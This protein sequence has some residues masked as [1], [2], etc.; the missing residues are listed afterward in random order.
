ML[1]DNLKQRSA[2]MKSVL[3]RLVIGALVIGVLAPIQ[4]ANAAQITNR[5]LT[6]GT[7]QASVSTTHNYTFTAPTGTTIL[8]ID[9]TYCTT[10]SG[11]CT[12]PSGLTT[13]TAT[14]GSTSNLGSGGAWTIGGTPTNGRIQISN[15]SNTGS[16]SAAATV[17]FNAVT[18]P[19]ISGS[20]QN[21]FYVRIATYSA[22]NWTG[23][24][25]T[26]VSA[27][28]VTNQIQV[29][30][31]VDETLNFCAFQT[32]VNCSSGTGNTVAMG[33]LTSSAATGG[34]SKLV[35][36]TNAASGYVIQYLGATLTC[37]ACSG[38]PTIAATGTTGATS[39]TGSAQFGI[40]AV[41]NAGT[42]GPAQGSSPSGGSGSASTN[43]ATGNT[44]SFQANTLTQIA[45]AVGSTADT[46]YTVSYLA[47]I[48]SNQ[49][50]GSYST[51]LTFICTAT[52]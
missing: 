21:T 24:L 28:S 6:L 17:N 12:L 16:P 15:A 23:Q 25:D 35:A 9:F 1:P 20:N 10:P 5:K 42:P 2:Q 37:A 39:T 31:N 8:S 11:T 46:L 7:S 41:A 14:I 51:T 29:T 30:A 50:A 38:A 43:Y 44:Y 48:P 13:T 40:N 34:S 4:V 49:A 19:S 3:T 52:F 22:A 26:G 45:A 33:T 47:N 36:G 27:A 18:N 32:G